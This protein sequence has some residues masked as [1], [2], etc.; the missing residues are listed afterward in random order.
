MLHGAGGTGGLLP[1]PCLHPVVDTFLFYG[2]LVVNDSEV[3][4]LSMEKFSGTAMG[5]E[6]YYVILAKVSSASVSSR[7]ATTEQDAVSSSEVPL[8]TAAAPAEKCAPPS[9]TSGDLTSN[10]GQNSCQAPALASS[11]TSSAVLTTPGQ[12]SSQPPAGAKTLQRS[13]VRGAAG[14]DGV[15]P[16]PASPM[17][18]LSRGQDMGFEDPESLF[19]EDVVAFLA[20]VSKGSIEEALRDVPARSPFVEKLT[21]EQCLSRLQAGLRAVR[22]GALTAA[23]E[24]DVFTPLWWL[25]DYRLAVYME[26]FARVV[27]LSSTMLLET[28]KPFASSLLHRNLAVQWSDY[29]LSHRYWAQVVTD[30]GT[31]KSPVMKTVREAF[32]RAVA[33]WLWTSESTCVSMCVEGRLTAGRRFAHV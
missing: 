11:P 20:A 6:L 12:S 10:A 13:G 9:P 17:H 25:A 5:G 15:L 26:A 23:E 31:G 8:G 30:I 33:S 16:P 21:F 1:S 19:E 4:N 18:S 14:V 29:T 28:F 32:K 22:E 24:V 2:W 3:N 7:P 27:A